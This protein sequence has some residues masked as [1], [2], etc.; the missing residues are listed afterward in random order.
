MI[1]LEVLC[2]VIIV[3]AAAA[4]AAGSVA[5]VVVVVVVVVVIAKTFEVAVE[6]KLE[7][8][9]VAEIVKAALVFL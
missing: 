9:M 7:V 2:E 6:V 5:V 1:V 3:A 4:A 8:A